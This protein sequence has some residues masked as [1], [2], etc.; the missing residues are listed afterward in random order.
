MNICAVRF[1]LI[2]PLKTFITRFFVLG[3]SRIS[4]RPNGEELEL[5]LQE[6]WVLPEDISSK[7]RDIRPDTRPGT[8]H[9]DI[10]SYNLSKRGVEPEDG[11]VLSGIMIE[12]TSSNS[13]Q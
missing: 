11:R 9:E 12:A 6:R 7:R 10:A 4:V 5:T 3:S 1:A 13:V 2:R 8:Y